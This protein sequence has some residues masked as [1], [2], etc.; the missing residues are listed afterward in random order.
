MNRSGFTLIEIL[1]VLVVTAVIATGVWSVTESVTRGQVRG[2]EDADRAA[3]V[4]SLD[5]VLR[6]AVQQAT[7]GTLSAP[8]AGPVHVRVAGAA[9][10]EADTL[11]VLRGEGPPL[12]HST[13]PCPGGGACLYLFG[14]AATLARAGDVLLVSVPGMGARVYR[15]VGEARL[16]RAACGADCEERLACTGTGLLAV[17]VVQVTE[18]TIYPSAGGSYTV[19]GPCRQ[20]Y[21]AERGRCVERRGARPG[22]V[23]QQECVARGAVATYTEVPVAEV[24]AALGFPDPGDVPQQSGAALTPRVQVQRVLPSRFWLRRDA[25]R[26]A[27]LLVRQTGLDESGAWNRAVPVGGPVSALEVQTLHAGETAWRRGVGVAAADLA[28]AAANA[29]YT[30]ADAPADSALPGFAFRRGYHSVGAVRVRF[31][32]PT[33]RAD[34]S[35]A[36]V[37]YTVVVATNG[38]SRG[39]SG[40]GW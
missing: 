38:A 20:A 37:P 22:Q 36:P 33:P 9:G 27:P 25:A 28:H 24:T 14:S 34:G 8:N 15:V 12:T 4:A 30:R 40:G 35:P 10:A 16:S 11:V 7:R 21:D 26:A 2:M 17:Q 23:A 6:N 5:A 39:G 1:G 31:T 29:N 32:V 18:S 19:P 3:A 13:R